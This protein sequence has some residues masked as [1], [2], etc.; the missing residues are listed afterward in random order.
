M[1]SVKNIEDLSG[2]VSTWV[3]LGMVGMIVEVLASACYGASAED[4]RR[5]RFDSSTPTLVVSW[6]D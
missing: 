5:K 4:I 3:V 1:K 6:A 2:N